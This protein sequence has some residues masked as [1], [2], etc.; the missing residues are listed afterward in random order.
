MPSERSKIVWLPGFATAL[1]LITCYGT[2]A[3]V[4]ILGAFGVAIAI[5][6]TL[7]AG[8]IVAFAALAVGGLAIGFSRHRQAWPLSVGGLGAAAIGYAMYVQYA[9]LIEIFGFVLLCVAVVW[10]WRLRRLRESASPMVK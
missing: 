4:A 1:S 5:N 9:L 3:V 10:D 8:A 7:W 6:E 2:L